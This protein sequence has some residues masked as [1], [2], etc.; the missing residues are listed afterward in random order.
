MAS[1]VLALWIVAQVRPAAPASDAAAAQRQVEALE[2]RWLAHESDPAVL[3]DILADDF[4]HVL[5]QGIITKND[6][7]TYM[8]AHAAPPDGATRRFQDLRVRVFGTAAVATGI[9]VAATPD[10][11]TQKTAFTDVFAVR[12]GRWRAVNA[13]ET[14]LLK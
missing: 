2:Q 1:I 9:V 7:L 12:D 5:P 8:R 3:D 4:L 11:K 10:G 14:P 6:Q 13:Q